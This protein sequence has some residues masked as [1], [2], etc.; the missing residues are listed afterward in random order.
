MSI[1]TLQEYKAYEGLSKTDQDVKLNLLIDAASSLIKTYLGNVFAPETSPIVEYI[2]VD[3]DTNR[4]FPKYW[5]LREVISVEEPDRYTIDSTVH[6]PLQSGTQY[7]VDGNSI[8][9]VPGTGGFANWPLSPR[10]VRV[11]YDGGFDVDS[12]PSDL[13]LAAIELV[14]Y[15][16]DKGFL[17]SRSL[18]GATIINSGTAVPDLPAHVRAILDYYK[19]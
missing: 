13:K 6:V 11:T 2:T 16:K 17:P 14:N 10:A 15:Y 18:Q 12:V 3:Y 7:Y 4:I 5:P 19:D 1:I 9:R 8:V